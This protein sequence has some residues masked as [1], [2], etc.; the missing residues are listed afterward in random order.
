[1][2]SRSSYGDICKQKRGCLFY[3]NM[4]L[5]S[6]HFNMK[7]NDRIRTFAKQGVAGWELCPAAS[8]CGGLLQLE[9]LAPAVERR[10]GLQ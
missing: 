10:D 3:V 9:A 8:C 5:K 6:T 7:E 1:M 2:S 4:L